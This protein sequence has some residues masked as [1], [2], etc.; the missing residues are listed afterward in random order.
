M[1]T[2]TIIENKD[3]YELIQI[4]QVKANIYHF[5]DIMSKIRQNKDQLENTK[6]QLEK[7]VEKS[8]EIND[9]W[10]RFKPFIDKAALMKKKAQFR[11]QRRKK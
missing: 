3:V 6:A 8:K 1:Q 2:S 4:V 5:L 9:D 10:E 7:V 11:E